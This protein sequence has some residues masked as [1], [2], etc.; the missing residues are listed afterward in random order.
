MFLKMCSGFGYF[1]LITKMPSYL[2]TIFGIDIFKNGVFSAS[3]TLAQGLCALFAAPLSN[4]I[5]RRFELPVLPVRKVFQSL[6]MLGPALCMALIPLMGCNSTPVTILLLAGMFAYGFFTAGEWTTG[7]EYAPNSAG[8]VFGVANSLAFVMGVVA[9]Y[10]VGILLD[11]EHADSRSQWNLIFY[12]TAGIYTV[13]LIPFLFFGTVQ[14]QWWD[15]LVEHDRKEECAEEEEKEIE[16][17][18]GKMA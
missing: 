6:A 3:T 8:T 11:S 7:S 17:Q 14:Q 1:L 12:L 15:K 16:R 4:W 9:P 18:Q 2:S 13:G 10:L 5:I